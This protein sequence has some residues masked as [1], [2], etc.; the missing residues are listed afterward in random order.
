VTCSPPSLSPMFAPGVVLEGVHRPHLDGVSCGLALLANRSD[1]SAFMLGVWWR[2]QIKVR[3]KLCVRDDRNLERDFQQ[4]SFAA[5][6]CLKFVSLSIKERVPRWSSFAAHSR[7]THSRC[8]QRYTTTVLFFIYADHVKFSEAFIQR[9]L[10]ITTS[11]FT[12]RRQT[13]GNLQDP[14]SSIIINLVLV[15]AA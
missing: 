4:S 3:S 6:R 7:S 2:A 12:T 10:T 8:E 15:Y 5:N 11:S 13:S 1:G 14:S 9:Q